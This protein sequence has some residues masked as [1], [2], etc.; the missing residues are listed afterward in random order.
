VSAHVAEA[1]PPKALKVLVADDNQDAAET[2]AVL[3]ALD[4]H[5][6]KTANDG[7]AALVIAQ[8][9]RP[10]VAVLDIGMPELNGF[11]LAAAIRREPWARHTRLI[12][13]TGWGKDQDKQ[14]AMEAGFDEHLTKPVNPEKLK[15]LLST[16][17]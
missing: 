13:L 15:A 6:V 11:E 14:Q 16:L 1:Q 10:D 5:L 12:A 4:G 9:F 7:A 8:T 17:G 2:L 3:L